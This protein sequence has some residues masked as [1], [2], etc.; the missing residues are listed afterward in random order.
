MVLEKK[1]ILLFLLFLV[2]APILNSW[3]EP[4]FTILKP[5]SPIMLRVKFDNNWCNGFSEKSCLKLFKYV[6]FRHMNWSKIML[7]NRE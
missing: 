4:S 3:P 1:F 2:T 5:W 6:I 7:V